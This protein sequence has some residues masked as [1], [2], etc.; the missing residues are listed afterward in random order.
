MENQAQ[1]ILKSLKIV[2][3]QACPFQVRLGSPFEW[4]L[5]AFSYWC[6]KIEELFIQF[7]KLKYKKRLLV[8]SSEYEREMREKMYFLK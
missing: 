6:G 4:G 8:T 3:Y 7:F 5:E 1:T 2:N